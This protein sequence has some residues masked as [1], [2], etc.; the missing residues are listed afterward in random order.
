MNTSVF[1]LL[2]DSQTFQFVFLSPEKKLFTSKLLQWH[3]E[4]AQ[5]VRW[6][7]H[8]LAESIKASPHTSPIKSRN[9]SLLAYKS[10][11]KRGH[12]FGGDVSPTGENES[13]IDIFWD[14]ELEQDETRKLIF[15]GKFFSIVECDE[16]TEDEDE[17][18]GPPNHPTTP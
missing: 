4:K 15:R 8:V 18:E 10:H 16:T 11:L 13:P 14:D 9:R 7:D 3:H 12:I 17:K 2:T 5:V 1:G 6:I